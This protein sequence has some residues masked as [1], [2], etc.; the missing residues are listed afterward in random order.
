MSP[1]LDLLIDAIFCRVFYKSFFYC[2][3]ARF[4]F[5]LHF[6]QNVTLHFPTIT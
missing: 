4:C 3:E 2:M 6:L 1:A 5:Q